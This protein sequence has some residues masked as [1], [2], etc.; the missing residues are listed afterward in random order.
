M[1]KVDRYS[2]LLY[3]EAY[4]TDELNDMFTD[5]DLYGH[6]VGFLAEQQVGINGTSVRTTIRRPILDPRSLSC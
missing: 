4:L 3:Q 6:D 5:T 1:L 2:P